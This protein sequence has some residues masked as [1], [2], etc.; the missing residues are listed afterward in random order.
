[1][2]GA[3]AAGAALTIV[4][5][6]APDAPGDTAERLVPF[7]AALAGALAGVGRRP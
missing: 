2:S 3:M 7:L 5:S 6:F 1:M 4:L